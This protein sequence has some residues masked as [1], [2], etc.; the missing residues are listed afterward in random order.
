VFLALGDL[1]FEG[2]GPGLLVELR[3]DPG[4]GIRALT[5]LSFRLRVRRQDSVH[6]DGRREEKREIGMAEAM[7]F[8]L[9]Q[10]ILMKTDKK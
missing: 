6:L 4:A 10:P 9:F 2:H 3:L 7:D 5:K 1:D 8:P